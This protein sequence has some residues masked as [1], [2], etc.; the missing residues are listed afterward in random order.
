MPIK[1]GLGARILRGAEQALRYTTFAMLAVSSMA[2]GV[3]ALLGTADTVGVSLFARSIPSITELLEATAA[4]AISGAMGAVQY[5]RANI[6][7]DILTGTFGPALRRISEAVAGLC[8]FLIFGVMCWESIKLATRSV[9][10]LELNH[11]FLAFPLYP[12]KILVAV[13]FGV[14]ALQF[15]R[16]LILAIAGRTTV[17]ENGLFPNLTG[18]TGAS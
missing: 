3:L 8:G 10:V 17:H 16:L 4:V 6:E 14:A 5:E 2:I 12:F 7:V 13:G 9:H 18:N 15:L 1:G 11:G